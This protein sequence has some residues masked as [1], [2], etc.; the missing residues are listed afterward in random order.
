MTKSTSSKPRLLKVFAIRKL[1]YRQK[2]LQLCEHENSVINNLEKAS[3]IVRE[4]TDTSFC[5][6]ADELAF[7]LNVVNKLGKTEAQ[8][9]LTLEKISAEKEYV[10]TSV[11]RANQNIDIVSKNERKL[12]ESRSDI[13]V[14]FNAQSDN[15]D[16]FWNDTG[17]DQ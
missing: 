7:R 10:G 12:E 8:N 15:F 13:A 9:K 14:P 11:N 17:F 5:I 16:M 4:L 3:K 1:L 6:S 2:F